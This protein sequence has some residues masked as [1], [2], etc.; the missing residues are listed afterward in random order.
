MHLAANERMAMKVKRTKGIFWFHQLIIF[1]QIKEF[2][3][4]LISTLS[5]T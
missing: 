2:P 4:S 5:I 1:R 3:V